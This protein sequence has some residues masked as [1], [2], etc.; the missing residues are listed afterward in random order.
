MGDAKK[1]S[2]FQAKSE[3][4]NYSKQ[5]NEQIRK[6]FGSRAKEMTDEQLNEA[7]KSPESMANAMY[8]KDSKVGRSMGNTEDGDGWKFRGRGMNQLTGRKNYAAASKELYGDD[9][10]VNDPDMANDPKIAAE[11][12]AWHL[13]KNK[14]A[15]AKKLG[16]DENNLKE[17]DAERLVA[18]STRGSDVMKSAKGQEQLAE[19][20]A[21]SKQY[22]AGAT[23][24][25]KTLLA[26]GKG[27]GT[28]AALQT[29]QVAA[30]EKV[31]PEKQAE[32]IQIASAAKEEP[33][34]TMSSGQLE[35]ASLSDQKPAAPTI[36]PVPIGGGGGAPAT[37]GG[38]SKGSAPMTPRNTDTSIRR[39]TDAQM[40]RGFA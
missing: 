35:G 7:K 28:T 15:M 21:Y 11:V 20:S 24:E 36:V 2:G 26:M 14:G 9:R 17:G 1:E 37:S 40:S 4:M 6:T 27:D 18:S 33:G 30:L 25:Q 13:K 10:L 5:S 16:I 31:A 22:A 34:G 19:V 8:G 38:S 23:K 12:S 29:N 3:N 32:K 39:I